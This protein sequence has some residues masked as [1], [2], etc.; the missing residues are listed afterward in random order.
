M[1]VITLRPEIF[2]RQILSCIGNTRTLLVGHKTFLIIIPQR[3]FKL[4]LNLWNRPI[5]LKTENYFACIGIA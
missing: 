1:T 2:H 5:K 3:G 4:K